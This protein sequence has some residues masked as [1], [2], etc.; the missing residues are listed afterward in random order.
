MA[1]AAFCAQ[2]QT[3]AKTEEASVTE[4]YD[5]V[6]RMPEFPGG[7]TKLFR[8][9]YENMQ[10]PM[11]EVAQRHQG[12]TICQFVVEKDGTITGA[13]VVRSSG[14]EALD[15]EALRIISIMPKWNPGGL[16]KGGELVLQRVKYTIPVNFKLEPIVVQPQ[17]TGG[18]DAQQAWIEKNMKYPKDAKKALYEATAICQFKIA[19]DGTVKEPELFVSTGMESLDKEALRLVAAMPK[20]QPG[21][22]DE[23]PVEMEAALIVNFSLP[24]EYINKQSGVTVVATAN[25]DGR[26]VVGTLPVPACREK[27]NGSVALRVLIGKDGK[28]ISIRNAESEAV[29]LSAGTVDLCRK[30]AMKAV[31][32]E[33]E[34]ESVGIISFDF[35]SK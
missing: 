8:F 3:E 25:V 26:T 2:A 1:F 19:E 12:R 29:M 5:V 16:H 6:E 23:K 30:A 31:F 10:Y 24:A 34:Q 20:W 28:V 11:L 9:I 32:N 7:Q 33:S 18:A 35:K 17:F 22:S 27:E 21:T 13:E 4:V 15:N 14:Y